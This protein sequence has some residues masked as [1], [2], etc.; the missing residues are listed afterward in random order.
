MERAD[1]KV[2]L[3]T[4]GSSGIGASA[5]AE[6]QDKGFTVYAV[7]RRVDRMADLQA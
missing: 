5:A 6:L 1:A 2:A 3:V 7:A 4:G